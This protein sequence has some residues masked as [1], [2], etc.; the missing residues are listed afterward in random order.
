MRIGIFGGTFN[1]IHT[2]HLLFAEAAREQLRLDRVLLIPC[3]QPPHKSAAGLL[4]AASR[5]AMIR[6]A[7]RGHSAFAASALELRRPGP[8]YT[9]DTVRALRRRWP[10]AALFL[11]MGQDMLGVRWMAWPELKQLCTV[12]VVPSPGAKPPRRER[13][14]V[15]LAMPQ[16]D[17]ASSDIRVRLRQG[18]SIRYLVP[19]AVERYIRSHRLY[20]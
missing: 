19:A 16:A 8:S 17:I 6:L 5:L 14:L 7:I 9:I 12:A 15:R 13:G 11:L 18:R 1:P 10:R 3:A 2:G 20:H 4:P